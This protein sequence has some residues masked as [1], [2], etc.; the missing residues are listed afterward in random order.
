MKDYKRYYPDAEIF[1]TVLGST[2]IDNQ[3]QE[4]L[5]LLYDKSLS[6]KTGKLSVVKD[7]LGRVVQEVSDA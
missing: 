3:G 2:N 4:G 6:G 1:A 7:R 5:E